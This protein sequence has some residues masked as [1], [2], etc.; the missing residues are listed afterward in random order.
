MDE[1]SEKAFE[2]VAKDLYGIWEKERD[3]HL[4]I[5]QEVDAEAAASKSRAGTSLADGLGHGLA[6]DRGHGLEID[7]GLS[8]DERK[9]LGIRGHWSNEQRHRART[10]RRKRDFVWALLRMVSSDGRNRAVMASYSKGRSDSI[11]MRARVRGIVC[12]GRSDDAYSLRSARSAVY[13]VSDFARLHCLKNLSYHGNTNGRVDGGG[14]N[15]GEATPIAQHIGELQST[16]W[17]YSLLKRVWERK[18]RI[19]VA[20]RALMCEVLERML[21]FGRQSYAVFADKHPAEL[22]SG[23][24][25]RPWVNDL[26]PCSVEEA[27]DYMGIRFADAVG[28]SG[29]NLANLGKFY[30]VQETDFDSLWSYSAGTRSFI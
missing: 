22:M 21:P 27:H 30:F 3:N 9:R 6:V 24:H 20:R 7:R 29:G 5:L 14:N 13:N 25:G 17:T 11:E 8:V 15:P 10:A 16:A 2:E 23:Q 19:P 12:G 18:A 28:G 26:V 1:R 4:R